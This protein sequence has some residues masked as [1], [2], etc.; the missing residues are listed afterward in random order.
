[1]PSIINPMT[2]I[3]QCAVQGYTAAPM[4]AKHTDIRHEATKPG[5]VPIAWRPTA[6]EIARSNIGR[7]MREQGCTDYPSLYR[8]SC[9]RQEDFWRVM[10]DTNPRPSGSPAGA[11]MAARGLVEH[12][13]ELF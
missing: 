13:G 9:E 2:P 4:N 12:H 3:F 7:L 6:E 8:W 11:G 1:M 10:L 5:A